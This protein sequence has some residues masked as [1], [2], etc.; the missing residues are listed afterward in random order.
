MSIFAT[1]VIWGWNKPY[2]EL[3]DFPEIDME[4][5]YNISQMQNRF[6]R[7]SVRR[8]RPGGGENLKMNNFS[9]F[10]VTDSTLKKLFMINKDNNV[11]YESVV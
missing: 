9:P 11:K 7:R 4:S 8:R 2:L 6:W 3:S 10:Y 1:L 5:P